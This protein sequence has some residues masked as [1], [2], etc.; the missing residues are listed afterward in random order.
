MEIQEAKSIFIDLLA[1]P[2]DQHEM[3]IDRVCGE[4][5][6]LKDRIR[7]LLNAHLSA[8]DFLGQTDNRLLLE[9]DTDD[10]AP[11]FVGPYRVLRTLG[12]GGFGTVYLCQQETP[13]TRRIAVKVLRP[14]MDT[15]SILRRFEEERILLSKM[16]HPGIARVLDAGKTA[17]GQPYIAMEY[18]EGVMVTTYCNNKQLK[19]HSRL[20]VFAQVCQA[21]QHAHQKGVIH[22]DIK[23]GNVLVTDVDGKA[24]V[25]VIDFGVSKA[26]EDEESDDTIT[27]TMQLVGTPQ[28]MSPE[29]ASTVSADIDTRTDVYSLGVM[30]YELTTGLPPFDP[31]RLKSASVG[32]LEQMI[33]DIDPQRPSSRVAKLDRTHSHRISTQQGTSI[34]HIVRDLKGEIDWII[35]KSMEKDRDRRYPTAYALYEDVNRV[36]RGD[37]VRARPPSK[38]YTVRKFVSRNRASTLVVGLTFLSLITLTGLSLRYAQRINHA[39]EQIESTLNTQEQVLAFTEQM[40]GGIDPAVARGQDTALFKMILES[41]SEK[42]N[43]ELSESA[44]VEVRVRIL[45]GNLY[46][47]IGMY[48]EAKEQFTHAAFIGDS[49]MGSAHWQSILA[50]TGLGT[51][52]VDLSEYEQAESI[53]EKALDDARAS[54]GEK[55]PDTFIIQSDLAGV[56]NYLGKT[57]QAVEAGE[58]L[59]ITRTEVLGSDHNDTMNT[60]N[61][62]ALALKGLGKFDRSKSLFEVVL[63]YQMEHL[64]EDHPITLKTRTNLALV[65]HELELYDQSV[66]MNTVILEQKIHVLG[67]QHPSVLVS[68]VNLAVSLEEAG[69]DLKSSTLLT[70][71]LEKSINTLGEEHQYSLIIRNNLAKNYYRN[72]DYEQAYEMARISS[73]G[74]SQ[75]LGDQHPMTLQG[76]GNLAEILLDMGSPEE[77]LLI[78]TSIYSSAS[79]LFD[80]T[81]RRLGMF[82]ERIG[83]CYRALGNESEAYDYFTRA[84]QLYMSTH[85]EDS[86]Q[87]QRVVEA[88]NSLDSNTVLID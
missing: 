22:R 73:E 75:S 12:Q 68:M 24:S 82:V 56:Y 19:L 54:L 26:F 2:H 34:G 69:Q 7:Q 44:E 4:N 62:L 17:N 74:L 23:P 38:V 16:D 47:S 25:K 30:L 41:A 83:K 33:R 78:A 13:I 6:K 43:E 58:S 84:S 64:G 71:A 86:E 15:R 65:Y 8:G 87:Y 5:D 77:A 36:L 80:P 18:I 10:T 60:R 67:D 3:Y 57:Q 76:K 46:R 45:I 9:N 51:V 35:L 59:L 42:V 48:N 79:E 88:L 53:F 39:N 81:D 21:I 28:Y 55:H 66:E 14:G 70:D 31:Q 52:L 50:R 32:Q 27:R 11:D 49:Q 63:A 40:L 1:I 20:A 37:V 61:S 29:Q 85:G 72:K